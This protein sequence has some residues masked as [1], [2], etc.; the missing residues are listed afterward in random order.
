M[1][2]RNEYRGL[3]IQ[4]G[5]GGLGPTGSCPECEVGSRTNQ[6][7]RPLSSL[8]YQTKMELTYGATTPIERA[9]VPE[10]AGLAS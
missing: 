4:L 3:Q 6:V 10:K 2:E 1:F 8:S 9:E 7:P 5:R